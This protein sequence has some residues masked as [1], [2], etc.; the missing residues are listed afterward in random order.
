MNALD[1]YTAPKK[2]RVEIIPLIDVIFFLLATFVLFTL[3]LEKIR[4]LEPDL[5]KT[6]VEP[7]PP[8]PNTVSIQAS[9][10]GTYYWKRGD[11]EPETV[12]TPELPAKLLAYRK[13]VEAP[14]VFIRSDTQATF[15]DAVR[16]LDEV[17]KA[18]ITQVAVETTASKTGR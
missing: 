15:G 10:S 14:R 1:A 7:G 18:G 12:L 9:T 17:R 6:T 16:V 11:G 5:P 13:S 8:D 4:V 2:A 3:S